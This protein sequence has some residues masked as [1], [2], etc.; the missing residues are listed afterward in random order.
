[1]RRLITGLDQSL[2]LFNVRSL[3]DA[4]A[5]ERWATRLFGVMFAIVA[6]MALVLASVG[7]YGLTAY[8]VSLRTREIGIRIA[9]GGR[10]GQIWWTVGRRGLAQ[11]AAG[12]LLGA[13][14]ALALGR[15]LQGMLP[16]AA[17]ATTTTLATVASL[18]VLVAVAACFVPAR[19]AL[20]LN[21][22][23]ALRAE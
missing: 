13:G 3:D 4:L 10:S 2:P 7:L 20:R 15:A 19:R 6:A 12:L 16:S 5:Y 1:M 8:A 23:D 11:V 22:V 14:G 9:L 17:G 21:P 18:L